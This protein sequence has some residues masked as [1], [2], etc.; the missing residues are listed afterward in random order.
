M[1]IN[2]F[3]AG[4]KIQKY[5]SDVKT[6]I[7]RAKEPAK[8]TT[9][10]AD[11]PVDNVQLSEQSHE[12]VRIKEAVET[13]PEIRQDKVDAVKARL[14]DGSYEVDSEEVADRILTSSLQEI[15]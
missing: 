8:K 3:D 11:S 15:V 7:D 6:G 1:K 5:Q 13:A 14:A 9:D 12:I 10:Q 2:D 4:S